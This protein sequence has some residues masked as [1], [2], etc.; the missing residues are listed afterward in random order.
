MPPDGG[1]TNQRFLARRGSL[2]GFVG[3]GC[4][5]RGSGDGDYHGALV[6][7]A[8]PEPVTRQRAQGVTA[9]GKSRKRDG[10]PE[11]GHPLSVESHLVGHAGIDEDVQIRQSRH[12]GGPSRDNGLPGDPIALMR[13]SDRYG[14]LA[15]QERAT[16]GLAGSFRRSGRGPCGTRHAG[17]A[18]RK[19]KCEK[20]RKET[21]PMPSRARAFH[22][23]SFHDPQDISSPGRKTTVA[24]TDPRASRLGNHRPSVRAASLVAVAE[25]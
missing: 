2:V 1:G 16:F 15:G 9:I 23:G 17:R 5:L 12:R 3:S 11:V 4:F 10:N 8:D 25:Q 22:S 19:R 20:K 13:L 6:L 18:E 14:R 21:K 7:T 24:S